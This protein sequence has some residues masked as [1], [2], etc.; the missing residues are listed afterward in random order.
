MNTWS[1]WYSKR[2]R[3]EVDL[4]CMRR[5]WGKGNRSLS[6]F[7]ADSRFS[8]SKGIAVQISHA[9]MNRGETGGKLA[10]CDA[11]THHT[12]ETTWMQSSVGRVALK[13]QRL[14]RNAWGQLVEDR[15]P[16]ASTTRRMRG[17]AA[18]KRFMRH[19]MT[20]Y[21]EARVGS[22]SANGGDIF[23]HV[24]SAVRGP[25][26]V[27]REGE[28]FGIG[29]GIQ[30]QTASTEAA[31][32]VRGAR[33]GNSASPHAHV[34]TP[35]IARTKEDVAARAWRVDREIGGVDVKS[36]M[37]GRGHIRFVGVGG[38]GKLLPSLIRNY[39]FFRAKICDFVV[40][41]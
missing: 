27:G 28:G 35:Q 25:G 15:I 38:P 26:A 12:A 32:A 9:G 6:N 5:R 30:I 36:K 7:Q 29:I 16:S 3:N 19:C 33:I 31:G 23:K 2:K 10:E 34:Y 17:R 40:Q 8:A 14:N 41:I 11:N 1:K 37:E 13:T 18:D 20:A 22:A 39:G 24:G 21:V 4:L